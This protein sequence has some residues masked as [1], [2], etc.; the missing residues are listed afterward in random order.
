MGPKCL[1][2]NFQGLYRLYPDL[3][4]LD[5]EI[6]RELWSASCFAVLDIPRFFKM[7]LLDMDFLD[8]V[9]R[10]NPRQVNNHN[11][12][13]CQIISSQYEVHEFNEA[14]FNL[15]YAG[16][17][18][19]LWTIFVNEF[20]IEPGNICCRLITRTFIESHVQIC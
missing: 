13:H 4:R 14:L 10:M 1:N 3:P 19:F 15:A 6:S 20:F 17:P 16:S 11:H 18:R 8:D 9:R 5:I 2:R 12:K 7:G